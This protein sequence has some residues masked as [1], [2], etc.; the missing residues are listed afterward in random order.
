MFPLHRLRLCFSHRMLC[1]PQITMGHLRTLSVDMTHA[2]R[3]EPGVELYEDIV[4]LWSP[5]VGSDD[6]RPMVTGLPE[7]S[8]LGCLLKNTPPFIDGCVF[9]LV[10]RNDHLSWIDALT[11]CGIDV[12]ELRCVFVM[13]Q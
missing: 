10:D 1:G 7:P 5:P 6:S 8:V 13:R 4:L 2:A 9:S 3:G 11:C 12:L